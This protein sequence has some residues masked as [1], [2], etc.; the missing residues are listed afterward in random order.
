[1]TYNIHLYNTDNAISNANIIYNTDRYAVLDTQHTKQD[2]KIKTEIKELT[3]PVFTKNV[4]AYNMTSIETDDDGKPI[5]VYHHLRNYHWNSYSKPTNTITPIYADDS[6]NNVLSFTFDRQSTFDLSIVLDNHDFYQERLAGKSD[7]GCKLE[8]SLYSEELNKELLI[9][10]SD[11]INTNTLSDIDNPLSD[12]IANI[13]LNTFNYTLVDE[14]LQPSTNLQLSN[15]RGFRLRNTVGRYGYTEISHH[16][17]KNGRFNHRWSNIDYNSYKQL[18]VKLT[19]LLVC[20]LRIT[21]LTG[22]PII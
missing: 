18:R 3:I 17:L 2:Y 7:T 19:G 8:I 14:E 1:M 20:N 9:I 22:N 15:L 10:S 5:E 16:E 12:K 4:T 6:I 11:N 21:Q 13:K